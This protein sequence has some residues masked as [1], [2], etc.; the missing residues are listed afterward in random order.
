MEGIEQNPAIYELMMQHTWQT[1]P[2]QVEAWLKKYTLNRYGVTNDSLIKAWQLLRATV[3][4]GEAIKRR[5]G[6]D[7]HR[8]SH[9]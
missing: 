7:R 9:V 1:Q 4:N 6:V 8:P 3:Y 2:V 5:C